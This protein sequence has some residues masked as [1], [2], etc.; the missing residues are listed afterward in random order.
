MVRRPKRVRMVIFDMDGVLVPIHSSWAYI[1]ERLGVHDEARKIMEKFIRGEIDYMRWMEEDTG[2]WVKATGGKITVWDLEKIL[3]E[4]SVREEAVEV[5]RW[6]R[7]R[8][9]IFG[10][11]SGGI[12]LLAKRVAREVGADFFL[13]NQLSY[14]KRGRLVPGGK[15]VVGVK[16]H[17][18]VKRVAGEYGIPLENVMFVGDSVWDKEAMEI[19]GY[20]VIYGDCDHSELLRVAKC[21]IR[22]LRELPHL[23][24]HIEREGDCGRWCISPPRRGKPVEGDTH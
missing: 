23:I 16:K 19:V 24:E 15:P 6:L 8:G 7:R 20:P 13:A 22:D 9:I 11:I 18:A 17:L 2:L 14:D 21:R 10:I 1:H 4:V 5:A 3:S 12:D